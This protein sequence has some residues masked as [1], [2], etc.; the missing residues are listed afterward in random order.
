M[1]NVKSGTWDLEKDP[2]M[3][4]VVWDE[5]YEIWNIKIGCEVVTWSIQYI[6]EY[7]NKVCERQNVGR[8]Y[9]TVE[10]RIKDNQ[11]LGMKLEK[12]IRILVGYEI[13][14]TKYT[15]WNKNM[16]KLG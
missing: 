1:Q 16:Q 8:V 14:N 13:W 11:D 6:T 9:L 4:N 2:S 15:V 7:Q 5:E 3:K 10:M 12:I